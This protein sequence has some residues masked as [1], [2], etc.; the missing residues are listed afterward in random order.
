MGRLEGKV[1]VVTS[2]GQ[3]IG[4]GIATRFAR[5]GAKVVVL[6]GDEAAG[7]G[8]VEAAG[9]SAE[10]ALAGSADQAA[11]TAA[12]KAAGAKHG[13]IDILVVGGEDAPEP[14]TWAPLEEKS[15]ADFKRALGSDVYGALFAMQAVFPFMREGGGSIVFVFSPF[16]EYA[17][18]HVADHMAGRWGA[19]GLA[20]T[21][22]HEWGAHQIRVN[23]LVPLADTPAFRAYRE[24]DPAE[25]DRRIGYTALKRMGDPVEDIG[26]AAVFLASDDTRFL[27]GQMVYA[28][29]GDVLTTPVFEPVWDV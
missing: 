15:E 5:E 9:A 17:S 4:A 10:F 12:I 19:L 2:G 24:R 1:A 7:R 29:G 16:G 3:A 21:A 14:Q 22:G 11:L 27:T 25:V 20:R 23:T 6:D 8:T 26:G 28:D 13:R 18:R